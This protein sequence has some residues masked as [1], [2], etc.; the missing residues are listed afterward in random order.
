MRVYRLLMAGL[1]VLATSV[2]ATAAWYEAKSRHFV[3]Y[4]EQKPDEL[5]RFAGD[6]ERFDQA[7]RRL[8]AM[9]DPPLTDAGR[10]KIFVLPNSGA[11]ARM[12]GA[13]G[14]GVAGFYVARASGALAFVHRE[15]SRS[16]YGLDARTVFFHEY[17][18]HLM[19]QSSERALP[20]WY[21]EGSAEMFST[22]KIKEDGAIEIGHVPVH[23]AYGLFNLFGLS[24]QEMVGG[25]AIKRS[26]S[27]W[28]QLYGRGWLLTHMLNFEPS[29]KGQ[30]TAYL[31]NIQKGMPPLDSATAAFGEMKKLDRDLDNYLRRRSITGITLQ[32]HLFK[33]E[34]VAVR[35]LPAAEAD[36]LP[37]AMQSER[38]VDR[39]AATILLTEVRRVAA[40]HPNDAHVL[41]A[42]AEAEHDAGNDQQAIA[43]AD[44]AIAASPALI[45]AHIMKSRAMLTAA[46]AAGEKADWNAVRRVIARANR[47]DP[48]AAEPLMLFYQSY[49]DQGAMPTKNAVEGLLYAQA[50]VPQDGSLRMLAV[51]Q[52][53]VDGKSAD[54]AQLFGV[55]AYDPHA[56]RD[57][58][59]R[60]AIMDAMTAGR[61]DEA[62]SLLRAWSDGAARENKGEADKQKKLRF[63]LLMAAR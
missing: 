15:R 45:K 14:S 52:L 35:A 12:A 59:Q 19:L 33:A 34:P 28:E 61:K 11:V 49:L 27:E 24:I 47:L 39:K 60:V 8:R 29:R 31:T 7:V 58:D 10:L 54:A 30:L 25:K 63:S 26:S 36:I 53:V 40:R 4:S 18:H 38:G 55:I 9:V 22:A 51:R 41:A 44:R 20:A 2:P 1:L 50:L 17:L 21:V 5:K 23:R 42:L 43:A 6:L 13:P 57:R 62:L 16:D 3:I 32:G 48:D 37:L 46:S 56:S